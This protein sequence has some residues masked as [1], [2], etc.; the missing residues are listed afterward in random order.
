[1]ALK[2]KESDREYEITD[3]VKRHAVPC[4]DSMCLLAVMERMAH[5]STHLS[6]GKYKIAWRENG[7]HFYAPLPLNP[8]FA[9]IASRFDQ[10]YDIPVGSRFTIRGIESRP[11]TTTNP[12]K[13]LAGAKYRA[14]IRA[15]IRKKS[16]IHKG[17]PRKQNI[18]WVDSQG[19]AT[20]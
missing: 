12:E 7:K 11:I 4:S 1:M 5:G 14:E 18:R 19:K 16:R 10:G 2:K 3:E 13:K 20:T 8:E 6:I 9:E 15:G 17:S